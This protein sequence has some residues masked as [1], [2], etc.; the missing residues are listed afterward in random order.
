MGDDPGPL[1]PNMTFTSGRERR[2]MTTET[3]TWV[4]DSAIEVII[5]RQTPAEDPAR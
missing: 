4:T 2:T 1:P 5:A 3:V